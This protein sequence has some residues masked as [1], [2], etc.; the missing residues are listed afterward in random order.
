VSVYVDDTRLKFRGRTYCHMVADT[1]AE[2][3]AM[4]ATIGL[5]NGWKQKA[6]TR[7][8]HY[9]LSPAMRR[10]AVEA[11]AVEVGWREMA[12]I[13]ARKQEAGEQS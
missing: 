5:K 9:D 1:S 4:A 7:L 3:D 2:L 13:T 8:E 12:A 6:G 11:G 10:R